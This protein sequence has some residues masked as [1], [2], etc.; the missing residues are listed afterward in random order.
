MK[1]IKLESLLAKISPTV[2]KR[3]VDSIE[4]RGRGEREGRDRPA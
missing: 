2:E 1:R 4:W 3:T